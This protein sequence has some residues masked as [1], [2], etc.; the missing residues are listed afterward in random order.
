[1]A[2]EFH[3]ESGETVSNIIH[4]SQT[5][6]NIHH[7]QT[8]K[9]IHPIDVMGV[10]NV[11]MVQ[12]WT[13]SEE[14]SKRKETSKAAAGHMHKFLKIAIG[15]KF[16]KIQLILDDTQN[17]YRSCPWPWASVAKIWCKSDHPFVSYRGDKHF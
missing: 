7:S 9:H 16:A 12:G 13:Q 5:F 17:L 10:L 4:H 6:R 2:H 3:K 8:F 11:P 1:M 15:K 14:I